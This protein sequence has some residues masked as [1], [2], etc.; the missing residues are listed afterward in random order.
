MGEECP[1][2]RAGALARL[3][4]AHADLV[5]LLAALAR[6]GRDPVAVVA[7]AASFPRVLAPARV[8]LALVLVAVLLVVAGVLVA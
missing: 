3:R 5:L 6:L 7:L 1:R 8:V 2:S 4:R